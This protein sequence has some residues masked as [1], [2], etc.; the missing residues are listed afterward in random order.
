MSSAELEALRPRVVDLRTQGEELA[1][2]VASMERR[3]GEAIAN[4]DKAA[5]QLRGYAVEV[6]SLAH[7]LNSLR[8]SIVIV[9]DELDTLAPPANNN[10]VTPPRGKKGG[11]A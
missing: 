4:A 3:L 7:T 6:G 1:E 9:L 5:V 2:S 10:N 8:G 11:G